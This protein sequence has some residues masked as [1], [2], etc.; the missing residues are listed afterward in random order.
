MDPIAKR[1]IDGKVIAIL[2]GI[3][4]Q[5]L[6][7]L[8]EALQKGGIHALEITFDQSKPESADLTCSAI[9]LLRREFGDAFLPGAGTVMTEEQVRLAQEAGARY[10]ISPN[11]DTKIISL[12]KQLNMASLPGAMTPSEISTAYA[13]G[14][15]IVKVFPA[16]VLGAGYIKAIRAPLKHIPMFAVGGI[17]ADNAAE[18]LA[19]GACGLGIGGALTDPKLEPED[20]AA[21]ARKICAAC[22]TALA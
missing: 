11:V 1:L 19:A 7:P 9:A 14:C 16:G 4:T 15:D 3:S 5:R 13:A 18:F 12:T 21:L 17:N 2:R 8:A 6:L 20:I 10:I 22:G